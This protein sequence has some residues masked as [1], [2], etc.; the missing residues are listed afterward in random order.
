MTKDSERKAGGQFAAAPW[1]DDKNPRHISFLGHFGNTDTAKTIRDTY[2][3]VAPGVYESDAPPLS[4]FH[5][6]LMRLIYGTVYQLG[7]LC[8]RHGLSRCEKLAFECVYQLRSW[9]WRLHD[10]RVQSSNR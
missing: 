3:E 8:N 5:Q 10:K 4:N 6:N 2:R 9:V 7:A 1:L